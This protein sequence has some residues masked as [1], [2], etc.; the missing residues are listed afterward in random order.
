MKIRNGFVSNSSSSSFLV[1]SNTSLKSKDNWKNLFK[2]A[3]NI[4]QDN[5]LFFEG[6]VEALIDSSAYALS[7]SVINGNFEEIINSHELNENLVV[8]KIENIKDMLL[9]E[10]SWL[11]EEINYSIKRE[12]R[13]KLMEIRPSSFGGNLPTYIKLNYFS[14]ID[15]LKVED[16]KFDE[17]V[18]DITR[19]YLKRFI[20][21]IEENKNMN[22]YLVSASDEGYSNML[23]ADEGVFLRGHWKNLVKNSTKYIKFEHS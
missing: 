2:N 12:T 15:F 20:E 8:I 3:N 22:F 5:F 16:S 13:E 14:D 10:S 1:M 4:N 21:Y 23:Y 18:M 19:N 9:D 17:F 7:N 11:F 6:D